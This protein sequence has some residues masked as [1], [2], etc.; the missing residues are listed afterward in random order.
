M[1]QAVRIEVG[2]ARPMA[3]T[4]VAEWSIQTQKLSEEQKR[5]NVKREVMNR[6]Q[7]AGRQQ[8]ND[9]KQVQ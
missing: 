6:T 5:E 9:G 3:D 7:Q 1:L 8:E 2:S 4:Y